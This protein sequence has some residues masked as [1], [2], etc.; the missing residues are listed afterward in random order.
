V[1]LWRIATETRTYKADDISGAGA[2][3]S[4]G[5][6]NAEN[7]S[8]VYCAQSIALAVLETAAHVDS[9]GLPLN[10]FLVEILV[11]DEV[12]AQREEMLDVGKIAPAWAAIPAGKASVEIGSQW[13][14]SLRTPLLLVP[15][16][17]VPEESVVLINPKHPGSG[18]VSAKVVRQFEY[19]RLLRD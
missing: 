7:E 14:T 2:A 3:I 17:I 10:R 6:W 19:N 5:R 11:P 16:V 9:F 4:P 15:S 8:I 13:L 1:K 12:W 18:K